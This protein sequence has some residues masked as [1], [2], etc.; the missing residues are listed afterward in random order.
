MTTQEIL[1]ISIIM[2]QILVIILLISNT[3]R[4]EN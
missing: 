2:M 4:N 1:H 3:R